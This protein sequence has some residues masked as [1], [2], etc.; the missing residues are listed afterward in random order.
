MVAEVGSHGGH[1]RSVRDGSFGTLSADTATPL[2]MVLTEVLQNAV[3]H[4]F[5]RG[6]EEVV[7]TITLTVRRLVGRLTVTVDDDGQGLPPDF[8]AEGAT[9][10]GLSIV[11]TLVESELGG[12]LEI[13][14]CP[15]GGTRVVLDVPI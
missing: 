1:V 5:Q 2:A 11:R 12:Q 14:P 4:G 8:E 3:E 10:L 13:G 15:G 6:V 7:G 9:S